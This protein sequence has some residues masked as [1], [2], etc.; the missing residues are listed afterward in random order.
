MGFHR[1]RIPFATYRMKVFEV[2]RREGKR[3]W[4]NCVVAHLEDEQGKVRKGYGAAYQGEANREL[5]KPW[6]SAQ[7]QMR[8]VTFGVNGQVQHIRAVG[9]RGI[10]CI[11]AQVR[12]IGA[13]Y[14]TH[15]MIRVG[16][17]GVVVPR[18]ESENKRWVWVRFPDPCVTMGRDPV[19]FYRD[20]IVV[21]FEPKHLEMASEPSSVEGR[22]IALCEAWAA[23]CERGVA[24][25]FAESTRLG[26]AV[27]AAI[28]NQSSPAPDWRETYDKAKAA[29]DAHDE[30]SF[31]GHI[32]WDNIKDAGR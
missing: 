18:P 10:R 6:E 30:A 11:G 7:G 16:S 9:T 23:E 4:V 1:D 26:D 5:G 20:D 29:Y 12:V 15:P 2:D 3:G 13:T 27:T 22:E 24:A 8:E 14:G 21:A 31:G 32:K 19:T 25:Y 28:P 17:K